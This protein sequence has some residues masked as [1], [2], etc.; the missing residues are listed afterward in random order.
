MLTTYYLEGIGCEYEYFCYIG[1]DCLDVFVEK[2]D[3]N[4]TNFGIFLRKH[5]LSMTN[6]EKIKHSAAAICYLPA[7]N[8]NQDKNH[9]KVWDHCYYTIKYRGPARLICN[10]DMIIT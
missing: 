8:V 5:M 10:L 3:K 2:M 6:D 9:R 7:E 4:L 1:E